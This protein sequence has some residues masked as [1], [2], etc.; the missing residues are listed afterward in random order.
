MNL[1]T[2]PDN[3]ILKFVSAKI[4]SFW[5]CW[6]FL[7]ESQAQP[8]NRKQKEMMWLGDGIEEPCLGLFIYL[9]YL[10]N[11]T[12]NPPNT[13]RDITEFMF[14]DNLEVENSKIFR[15]YAPGPPKGPCKKYVTPEIAMFDPHPPLSHLVTFLPNPLPPKRMTYFLHADSMIL[16]HLELQKSKNFRGCAPWTPKEIAEFMVLDHLE[17]PNSKIFRGCA[18]EPPRKILSSWF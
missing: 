4:S 13:N 16:N 7:N 17:L 5:F 8:K 12:P 2:V 1:D 6:P 10:L 9:Y 14:L 18:P 11:P 15:G 3:L